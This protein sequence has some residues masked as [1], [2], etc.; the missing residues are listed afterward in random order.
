M[1][2]V[3]VVVSGKSRW[4]DF[5]YLGVGAQVGLSRH[6]LVVTKLTPPADYPRTTGSVAS[7]PAKAPIHQ[8]RNFRSRRVLTCHVPLGTAFVNFMK[9][10]SPDGYLQNRV[11]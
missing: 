8:A 3:P 9:T 6:F 7:V 11:K 10:E 5:N 4:E 1:G 2:R